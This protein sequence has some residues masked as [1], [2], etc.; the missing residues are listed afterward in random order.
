MLLWPQEACFQ[1]KHIRLFSRCA[2]SIEEIVSCALFYLTC[3]LVQTLAGKGALEGDLPKG[4]AWFEGC[5]WFSLT[6]LLTGG[7]GKLV[8][9]LQLHHAR[10]FR[11]MSQTS[12]FGQ[13]DGF[14]AL[15][16]S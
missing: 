8:N 9:P 16:Q 10:C 7:T 5:F 15:D 2:A 14:L 3:W 12:L 6:N 13:N 11:G 4:M 1:T